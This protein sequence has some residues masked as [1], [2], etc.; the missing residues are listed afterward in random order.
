MFPPLLEFHVLWMACKKY[1][2]SFFS[3]Q[4]HQIFLVYQRGGTG[5]LSKSSIFMLNCRSFGRL[6]TSALD[7]RFDALLVLCYTNACVWNTLISCQMCYYSH[8]RR[9]RVREAAKR[10]REERRRRDREL[11]DS[12]SQ[13]DSEHSSDSDVFPRPRRRY[14]SFSLNRWKQN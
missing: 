1:L 6:L 4:V 10:E 14:N 13:S 7:T 12:L 3:L 9:R 8:Q 11:R 2:R 5:Q